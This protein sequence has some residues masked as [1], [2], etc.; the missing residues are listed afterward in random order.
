[1]I[2]VLVPSHWVS[3]ASQRLRMHPRINIVHPTLINV[4][5]LVIN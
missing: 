4:S 3:D 5:S 1:M 2:T